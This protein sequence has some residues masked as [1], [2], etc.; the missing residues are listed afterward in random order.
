MPALSCRSN[1]PGSPPTF[2]QDMLTTTINGSYG[3]VL[4]LIFSYLKLHDG[5]SKNI[6]DSHFHSTSTYV[7]T[8]SPSSSSEYGGG[9]SWPCFGLHAS[10]FTNSSEVLL[11][12]A[13]RRLRCFLSP[14]DD[15]NFAPLFLLPGSLAQASRDAA[16]IS[17]N[18]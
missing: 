6:V 2:S 17:A 9:A 16:S 15:F 5:N 11:G 3:F 18:S 13:P 14:G 10:G 7:L 1:S 4:L 12:F 8:T